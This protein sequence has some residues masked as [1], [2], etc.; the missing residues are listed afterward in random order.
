MPGTEPWN[1]PEGGP[2]T[3]GH[4]LK[5]GGFAHSLSGTSPFFCLLV[6]C[7]CTVP[8]RADPHH[9]Q[10]ACAAPGHSSQAL[11]GECPPQTGV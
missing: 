6:I 8:F 2:D 1:T 4:V 11:F 5:E 7:L 3:P 10:F 9:T